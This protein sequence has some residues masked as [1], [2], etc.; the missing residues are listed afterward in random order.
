MPKC[1]VLVINIFLPDG[2][3][4]ILGTAT[5]IFLTTE[6]AVADCRAMPLRLCGI[7]G[8]DHL[9]NYGSAIK[10]IIGKNVFDDIVY[11]LIDHESQWSGP[12]FWKWILVIYRIGI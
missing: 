6:N 2:E 12:I 5:K 8:H 1:H 11:V 4:E 3:T 9:L 10:K 7:I